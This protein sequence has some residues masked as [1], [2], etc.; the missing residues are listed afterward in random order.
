MAVAAELALPKP[1][2]QSQCLKLFG[3]PSEKGWGAKNIEYI[4]PPFAMTMGDIPISR[5]KINKVAA[6]ALRA[7]F[8]DIW[9]ACGK[10]QAGVARAHAD[11]FSGDWV[12]R[13]IR[14]GSTPSMHS[15]ALAIDLDAG[16]NPL[17]ALETFFMPGSLV[18]KCF[19]QRGF[20]WGGRWKGR[21]DAM[22]FQYA[23]VG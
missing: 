14:G 10:T 12:V 22:H 17:G 8:N 19:E 6:P 13:P 9:E 15:F 20:I 1:P 7:A 16:S 3:N 21:R 2:L 5:V 18:V 4:A 11:R 23:R